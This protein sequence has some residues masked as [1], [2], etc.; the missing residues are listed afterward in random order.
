M[1]LRFVPGR[2]VIGTARAIGHSVKSPKGGKTTQTV[3][4]WLVTKLID[5]L[6]ENSEKKTEKETLERKHNV[7]FM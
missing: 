7:K 2:T 6:L 1:K 3:Y 5:R 4:G